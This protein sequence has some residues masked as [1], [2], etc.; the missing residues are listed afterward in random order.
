MEIRIRYLPKG[1]VTPREIILSAGEYFDPPGD[2]KTLSVRSCAK[3][4][5]VY[6]YTPHRP[7][8]L[9]WTVLEINDGNDFWHLRTLFLDGKRGF[10][11]H[12]SES[13]GSEEIIHSTDLSPN[14]C[15]IIRTLK[16]PGKSW[17]VV[18]NMLIDERDATADAT[19]TAFCGPWSFEELKEFGN[20]Q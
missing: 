9:C 14:Y 8:E 15:H 13:D 5:N 17:S 12:S 3:L 1:E 16:E 4:L 7:D 2:G 20:V 19:I 11:H 6:E 10:M 18:S